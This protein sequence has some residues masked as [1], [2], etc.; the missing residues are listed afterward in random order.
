MSQYIIDGEVKLSGEIKVAGAK[1]A[2]LKALA[3]SFLFKEPITVSNVP[4]IEDIQRM[5]EILKDIGADIVQSGPILKIDPININNSKPNP[6]LI[7]QL[8]SSIMIAGPLLAR[9]GEVT[10]SHPGGCVIGRRPIDMFLDGFKALGA[11]IQDHGNAYT[12]KAGRLIGAKIV[13]PKISVTVTESLMMTA[14][15]AQGTTI[16]VNA[17]MERPYSVYYIYSY[18]QKAVRMRYE[19]SRAEIGEL[20]V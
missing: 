11:E 6:Q 4:D 20:G 1:N 7:H 19:I 2:A 14:C 5:R 12:L 18:I 17:A 15:L 13:L 3:V 16:I 9:L 8:R 10:L